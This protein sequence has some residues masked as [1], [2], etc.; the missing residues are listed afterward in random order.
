MKAIF[1]WI[2]AALAI[3]GV[4]SCNDSAGVGG[5][6]AEEDV[7]IV[8]DSNFTVTASDV[9][10][11]VVQSRTLSQLI[12][13]IAAP[14]YGSIH[15]D[16]VGQMMPSLELDTVKSENIDSVKL[17][18][19]M[20]RGDF[21]GDSL[22]PMGL[23]VYRL[24][25]DLPYPIYS[26]FDPDGYY[27]PQAPLASAVY[28]ASTA[29]E[30]DSIK[31][32][33]VIYKALPLPLSLGRELMNAYADN[34]AVFADPETFASQVFKGL[35]IK[36][37]YGSGRITD[38]TTTSIRIYYH[39]N[40]YN[41]DSARYELKNYVGDY[42]AVTPEVVVN[43]NIRYTPADEL[44]AMT[45][46]DRPVLAA[47]AGYEAEIR[48]PLHEVMASYNRYASMNRVLNA[49]TFELPVEA[50]DNKYE[51]APPPYVLL[52]LKNKKDEFFATNSLC[53]N[54]TSFYATYNAT[55]GSY[56]FS[57][58]ANYLVKM[59]EKGDITPDD[60]TFTLT[61]VQ[62]NT[63]NSAS[64]SSYY[65]YYYGTSS[66]VS[67]IVPYVSKPAMCRI[68]PSDAKIKLTFSAGNN[69]I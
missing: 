15:S 49:L 5:S 11:N 64:S 13:D 67:S 41:T 4:V 48:F 66:V 25:R 43:N 55:N 34:P 45:S 29:N 9:R 18:V 57:G 14:G 39:R 37:S 42:F 21:V 47:P 28:T 56:T 31:K 8:I 23:E 10:N 19:Q 6:L 54:V 27:D 68:I 36:S 53:D 60:Y 69:K 51:I 26:D 24:N 20:N 7:V 1:Y 50:I 59:L 62:V 22:V 58:L 16:F 17:F 32:L 44:V 65:D 2:I 38:F 40:V 61:P 46:S 33:E 35:Y 52:I 12:G 3:V 63:E 30:P